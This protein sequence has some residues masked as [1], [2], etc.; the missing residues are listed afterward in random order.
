MELGRFFLHLLFCNTCLLNLISVCD[1]FT[2][3][4]KVQ[5]IQSLHVPELLNSRTLCY[6][7]CTL[8]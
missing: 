6:S 7:E 5:E 3:L 1:F 8:S 2:N 4:H